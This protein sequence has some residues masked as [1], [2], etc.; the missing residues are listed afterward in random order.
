[1]YWTR[2]RVRE[3]IGP[4]NGRG[5][6][7][8]ALERILYTY[9]SHLHTFGQ[10]YLSSGMETCDNVRE[11]IWLSDGGASAWRKRRALFSRVLYVT[12]RY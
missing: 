9:K 8:R 3:G 12:A 11:G 2:N 7:Q 1:M 10:I 5:L 6:G 4:S